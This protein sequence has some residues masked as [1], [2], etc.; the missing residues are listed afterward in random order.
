MKE[1]LVGQ[2]VN[3]HGLKGELRI[4]SDFAYKDLVFKKGFMV[5]VGTR[6]DAC[7]INSYRHHKIY[8]M[9][10][11]A[12]VDSIDTA[13]AYKGDFVYINREDLK[14]DGYI[15][16]DIIGF[17]VYND[18]KC[19]GKIDSI[20]NNGAHDIL[21]IIDD[22]ENKFMIPLVDEYVKKVDIESAK[23]EIS[24]IEGMLNE[25]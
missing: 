4:I 3:T 1:V 25:N 15:N 24:A 18:N 20:V 16:E 22:K 9:V 7:T 5:Y 2:I 19:I 6:R 14:I 17:D 8:D 11:F 10:T 13:I 12:D 21:V 23:V